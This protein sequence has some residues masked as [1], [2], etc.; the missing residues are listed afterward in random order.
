MSIPSKY[1]QQSFNGGFSL[2]GD[3]SRLAPNMYRIGFNLTNRYD[4]MD[5]ISSSIIDLSAPVGLKQAV[6]TFGNYIIMFVA[7]NA[8]YKFYSDTSWTIIPGFKMSSTATRYWTVDIPV[9]ITN[10]LRLSV[11]NTTMNIPQ[12]NGGIL[13]N[14]VSGAAGGNLPGLLVQDNIGQPQFI[15]LDVNG[16]PT[17]RTTQ[18]YSQWSITFTNA[19]NTTVTSDNREY[20]P[21]GNCMAWSSGVLYIVSQDFN[22]IY[23]SVSGRPLDFVINVPATLVTMAPFTM[24]GGGDATTTSTSVGVGGIS[25]IRPLS[26]GGI[27]VS[28]SGANFTLAPNTTPNAPTIFGEYTFIRTFLFNGFCLSDRAIIDSNGD[29]RFIDLSGI[30]SFNAVE[31]LQNEGRNSPF[32]ANIQGLF[33]GKNS[34]IVQSSLNACVLFNNYELYS[35]DTVFGSLI[36]KYDT[37]NLCW[38]SVDYQQ[39]D[40]KRVK[41]FAA[42]QI[43]VL[44]LFGI[45]EDDQFYQFYAS[46][47]EVDTA[48]F[49][50]V[51]ITANMLYAN[52]NIKMN[53]PENEVKLQETRIILN[54]LT[55]DCVVSFSNYINNRLSPD[56]PSIKTITYSPPTIP[57]T[58][59]YALQDV[60]TQLTNV[61][62]PT[63]TAKQGWKVYGI[64]S[65]NEGSITQ[66]FMSLSNETPMNPANSQGIVK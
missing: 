66:F 7:G 45:T 6:D 48:S 21:I 55:K 33:N 41:Q 58:D 2:L 56:C 4:Q 11:L 12:A 28:A 47:T 35:V 1:N 62:F 24:T 51:G 19:N 52:L 34:T 8:Y 32:S 16:I 53:N 59:P 30:R 27:F 17:V 38:V 25:C 20:V 29:T 50:T 31:Q 44:A 3:D 5:L 57:T 15:F 37:I 14:L 64:F 18:N 65:W 61:L 9:S 39:T 43:N 36:V 10:Y 60:D 54:N 22:T 26:S 40:N 23:R 49:R 42:L 13:S 63:P 46:E